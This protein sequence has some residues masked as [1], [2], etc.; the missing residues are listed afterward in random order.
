[1]GFSFTFAVRLEF[2]SI[3]LLFFQIVREV[4]L[5]SKRDLTVSQQSSTATFLFVLQY[6]YS[7]FINSLS[8]DARYFPFSSFFH[9]KFLNYSQ[10]RLFITYKIRCTY[11]TLEGYRDITIVLQYA[12]CVNVVCKGKYFSTNNLYLAMPVFAP[13]C[14]LFLF[15]TPTSH[16]YSRITHKRI[17]PYT[18]PYYI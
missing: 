14:F 7:L 4:I 5:F 11:W 9:N 17:Q 12:S 6:M 2:C 3:L 13:I 8:V 18:M 15:I 1:M 10:K 16:P